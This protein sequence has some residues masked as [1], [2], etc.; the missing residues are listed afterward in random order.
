MVV[1]VYL[2]YRTSRNGCNCLSEIQSIKEMLSYIKSSS[3]IQYTCS[4]NTNCNLNAIFSYYLFM[5]YTPECKQQLK[6]M[7]H[8]YDIALFKSG[9]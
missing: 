5:V 1:V 2:K 8:R 7:T 6:T 4:L 9:L 3:Y